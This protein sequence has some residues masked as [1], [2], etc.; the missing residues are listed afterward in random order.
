MGIRPCLS[1]RRDAAALPAFGLFASSLLR[2]SARLF[3]DA[4]NSREGRRCC[5]GSRRRGGRGGIWEGREAQGAKR[6]YWEALGEWRIGCRTSA[7]DYRNGGAHAG[8]GRRVIEISCLRCKSLDID[9]LSPRIPNPYSLTASQPHSLTASQSS[10]LF[11]IAG[12]P[13]FTGTRAR[14]SLARQDVTCKHEIEQDG[15]GL[16]TSRP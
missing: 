12:L 9:S 11:R 14:C 15:I 5:S 10:A 2:V 8:A 13:H 7:G 4:R 16:A 1:A 3:S 6:G